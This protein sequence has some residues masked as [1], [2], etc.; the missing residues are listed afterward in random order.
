MTASTFTSAAGPAGNPTVTVAANAAVTWTNDSGTIH[1]VTFATPTAALPVGAGGG[2][3][4]P[5]HSS[6]SNQRRFAAAGS[7]PFHCTI[8]GTPTSGM[9]GSVTV[10]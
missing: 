8:H 3:D 4:I 9:R 7:Y 10:Q 6:G 5:D 1:N 2:G